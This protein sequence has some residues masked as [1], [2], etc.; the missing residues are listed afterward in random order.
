M[1]CAALT[2][3]LSATVAIGV[4]LLVPPAMLGL[5][6]VT[7]QDAAD[8]DTRDAFE[9]WLMAVCAGLVLAAHGA[10]LLVVLSES[11]SKKRRAARLPISSA[12]DLE[13]P[14]AARIGAAD[15]KPEKPE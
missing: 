14:P 3:R 5:L 10:A 4:A 15:L 8:A 1:P 2:A 9:R 12:F 6:W 13:H 7:G 11:R